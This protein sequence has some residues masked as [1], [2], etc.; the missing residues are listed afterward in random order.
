VS[1]NWSPDEQLDTETY[2]AWD[3]DLDEQDE[4][5]PDAVGNPEGDR[6]LDRQLTV[7]ET[8]LSE[9]GSKLD[10][11]ERM[12]TLEGGMDDPDGILPDAGTDASRDDGWDLDAGDRLTPDE[13]YDD[14]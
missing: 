10:D 14:D 12:A 4:V 9:L 11:P 7:D 1:D 3:E 2:E 5:E 6:S 8:E 13:D